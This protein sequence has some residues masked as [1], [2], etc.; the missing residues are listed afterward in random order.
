ME[1]LKDSKG[2]VVGRDKFLVSG[3]L[4]GFFS[5]RDPHWYPTHH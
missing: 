4:L 5:V 3:Y 2:H 1:G